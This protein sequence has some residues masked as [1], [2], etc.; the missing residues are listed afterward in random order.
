MLFYP[1]GRARVD[2]ALTAGSLQLK[3][4]LSSR[5]MAFWKLSGHVSLL[6]AP[7][8]AHPSRTHSSCMMLS[9]IK[10]FP[11][12]PTQWSP[13]AGWDLTLVELPNQA[14]CG[15]TEREKR[16][17]RRPGWQMKPELPLRDTVPMAT[18]YSAVLRHP[19]LF[20]SSSLHLCTKA[21]QET[22]QGGW[23]G[24]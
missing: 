14:P 13:S 1:M 10:H 18:A 16:E 3:L 24:G 19:L 15:D 17:E 2:A 4:S 6:P 11:P 22:S 20:I 12:T 9:S 21:E 8:H 7:V 23:E 5:Y